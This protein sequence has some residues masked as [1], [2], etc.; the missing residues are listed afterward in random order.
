M[1][2]NQIYRFLLIILLT[3]PAFAQDGFKPVKK[4]AIRS[5]MELR[6]EL[7]HSQSSKYNIKPASNSTPWAVIMDLG[8]PDEGSFSV[9]GLSDGNGSIYLSSGGGV[10]GGISHDNVV[11]SAKN[12]VK[13][14]ERYLP[15]MEKINNYPLPSKNMVSFFIITDSGVYFAK[16][17]VN[18]VSDEN[19]KLFGMFYLANDL[20]SQLR[21]VA[22]Q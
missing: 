10:I 20:M 5:T 22:Q 19:H 7:L 14:S 4:K 1:K 13:Y 11:I 18:Q 2:I 16:E 8:F 3:F 15:L 12:L 17:N 21:K 9:V 6:T